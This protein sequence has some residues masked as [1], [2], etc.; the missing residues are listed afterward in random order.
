MTY[1]QI[2]QRSE[3]LYVRYCSKGDRKL[4]QSRKQYYYPYSL[5]KLSFLALV[6]ALHFHGGPLA[7][8]VHNTTLAEKIDTSLRLNKITL[9]LKNAWNILRHERRKF[10]TVFPAHD[11]EKWPMLCKNYMNGL[12]FFWLDLIQK[13]KLCI[14]T[15]KFTFKP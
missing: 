9:F 12:Y 1:K 5:S 13:L 15:Y 14:K 3:Y 2:L 8:A 11:I 7:A 4:N 10:Y 6:L